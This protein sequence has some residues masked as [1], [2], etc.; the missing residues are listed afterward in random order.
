MLTLI[1]CQEYFHQNQYLF[2][3]STY[4]AA[5]TATTRIANTI[6]I[7]RIEILLILLFDKRYVPVVSKII[8]EKH[9]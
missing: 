8:S 6:K 3:T 5:K 9:D 4:T 7:T 2:L 1:R